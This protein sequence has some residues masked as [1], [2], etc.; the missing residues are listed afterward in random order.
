MYLETWFGHKLA[1]W[2]REKLEVSQWEEVLWNSE[3]RH[4][5]H[6]EGGARGG[7]EACPQVGL[8][9]GQACK[10]RTKPEGAH[11]KE[12]SAGFQ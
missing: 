11:G 6:Q 1:V 7:F 5:A 2:A 9:K 12:L 8:F 3:C 10:S 4:N